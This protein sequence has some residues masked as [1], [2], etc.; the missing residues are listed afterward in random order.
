MSFLLKLV[1]HCPHSSTLADA[2]T[3]TC[4]YCQNAL[5][6]CSICLLHVTPTSD[7]EQDRPDAM[8]GAFVS[9]QTCRHGGE[10][11]TSVI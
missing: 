6:R 3:T 9:C 10:L 1:S 2:Q 8:G 5:P 7:V 11:S 4:I